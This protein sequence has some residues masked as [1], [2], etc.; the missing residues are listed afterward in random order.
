[1]FI[2][3]DGVSSHVMNTR[4]TLMAVTISAISVGIAI[5]WIMFGSNT[6]VQPDDITQEKKTA[7]YN[8]V[9]NPRQIEYPV[10]QGFN[11]LHIEAI[12]H[13]NPYVN[14]DFFANHLNIIVHHHCKV[15]DDNTTAC[16]LFPTGMGD[17]DKP[18]GIEYVITSEQYQTLSD[19]E[20]QYWH[21]H[22][23]EFPKAKAAFPDLQKD[24]LDKVQPVL[25]E[26]YGKVFYFWQY[27]NKFPIGEPQVLKIQQ[28]PEQ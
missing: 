4:A 19:D 11:D 1:M 26:T 5:G 6:S 25:D 8:E 27:P 18:Y 15:Y 20:K 17:Q 23:T 16:L 12:R 14:G 13:I 10:I 9:L 3:A 21:Y 7:T 2:S 22:K 24:E 28:L